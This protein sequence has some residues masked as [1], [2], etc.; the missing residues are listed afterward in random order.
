M[1]TLG[2]LSSFLLLVLLCILP[3][4]SLAVPSYADAQAVFSQKPLSGVSE[5]N[6]E[7]IAMDG[8]SEKKFEI[9]NHEGKEYIMQD[10][11][12]CENLLICRRS[13]C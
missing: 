11:L 12:I 1:K 2:P 7:G 10:N 9:W 6:F 13:W 4:P 3:L 5:D 8:H